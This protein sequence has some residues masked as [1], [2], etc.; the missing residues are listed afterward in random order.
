MV[1]FSYAQQELALSNLRVK[2]IRLSVSDTFITLDTFSIIPNSIEIFENGIR[3][4]PEFE[5][6]ESK[7]LLF[8]KNPQVRTLMITYRVLPFRTRYE[9]PMQAQLRESFKYTPRL[10]KAEAIKRFSY[11]KND[12]LDLDGISYNGS[13]YR[14][15]T[16]GN[17]QD[18]A[19]HSGFNMSLSG[20]LQ[21]G[22]EIN[23]S[24]TDA[25]IPLQPE[26]NSASLQEFDRI[27]IQLK[28]DNHQGIV[29]DFDVKNINE[30]YFLK[31]DRKLQG[32]T[33]HSKFDLDTSK[34]L[35]VGATAAITRGVFARNTFIAKEKNQGPY[36]LFGN[37]GESFLIIIAGTEKVFINGQLMKRGFDQDYVINYNIGEIV[38]TPKRLITQDLRIIV[39]F[40]YSDRNFFR[41][42]LEAHAVYRSTKSKLYAQIF[43]ESDNKNQPLNL[44]LN[45]S[46]ISR[47]KEIGNQIDSAYISSESLTTWDA[48]RITYQRKDTVVQNQNYSNIFKWAETPLDTVYTVI[49]TFVGAN[50]GHYNIKAS[51][52]NGTVF[53]WVA[54]Q[55]GIF[56]GSYEAIT[57]I[58]TPKSHLQAII[59]GDIKLNSWLQ[60]SAEVTYTQN[61]LNEFSEKDND[62]N[63]GTGA[64]L[65]LI[66]T[67]KIDSF[68]Q[69]S[70][71]IQNEYTSS[72]FSPVTRFRNLEFNRDWDLQIQSR[73]DVFQNMLTSNMA[74]QNKIIKLRTQWNAFFMDTMYQGLQNITDFEGEK[75]SIKWSLTSNVLKTK[76]LDSA[77]TFFRPKGTFN[78]SFLKKNPM[79]ASVGFAF[80]IKEKKAVNSENISTNS[81]DWKN[82]FFN[83]ASNPKASSRFNFG[84]IYRTER[85][86]DGITF[87]TPKI[88]SHTLNLNGVVEKNL[89]HLFKYNFSYRNFVNTDTG[90]KSKELIHNYLGRLDYNGQFLRGFMKINTLYELKAGQEQKTQITYVKAT[91]GY[92]NY[93]WKDLNN[94]G[95]FE[96]DEAYVSNFN[97]ENRYIRFYTLLPDFVPANEILFNHFLWLQPKAIWHSKKDWRK[98]ASKFSYQLRFDIQRKSTFS[99]SQTVSEFLSPFESVS[100]NN[101]IVS[102]FNLF[103][104]LAFQKNESNFGADLE[105]SYIDAKNLMSNGLESYATQLFNLKLRYNLS[106][107][108]TLLG[109]ISNGI[110]RNQSDFFADRNY[111]FILN[112][113]ENTLSILP[114]KN[115]KINL[116][117]N[118][119]FKSSNL[120]YLVQQQGDIELLLSRKN[121]GMVEAKFST[122][123]LNYGKIKDNP[124]V[125]LAML[126]GVQAGTNF[127]WSLNFGQK[128]TD[129]LQLNL[130]YNGR[131]NTQ[132]D[133]M[134]HSAN[135]EVR[136]IF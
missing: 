86:S 77:T 68:K 57:K 107:Y 21:N 129:L 103:N 54:P 7:A 135:M 78:Y 4:N 17:N 48:A 105:W 64:L 10:Y 15:V 24:I 136:A 63:S 13:L 56:Q 93:A 108:F 97:F 114:H 60:A 70:I 83:L 67:K 23:A 58:S 59:G 80:E 92:G 39:E 73:N 123:I 28:K 117:A 110:K 37:N 35:E 75:G 85:Y 124:Q 132:S 14:G 53:E 51:S 31:Y 90:I 5:Y 98:W 72:N 8:V 44:K 65:K 43:S 109:K 76:A 55:N 22:L 18:M 19:L 69:I 111:S 47:L 61:D 113:V 89:N 115:L 11:I 122:L 84:Y 36:R 49:F 131:K 12:K 33:Y 16:V 3:I 71:S 9:N 62:K 88:I 34:Q 104:Q 29:G 121:N 74:Y 120:Q 46:Q 126:N 99:Q 133:K 101:L 81:F 94:N 106:S 125:E 2:T 96:I 66:G 1:A 38:F 91:N 25:N 6:N 52:A 127:I 102:R 95:V 116:N 118:Y 41:S 100:S 79:T 32:L 119:A 30:S 128:L 27:F 20:R 42:T 82:Y 134:I 45:E 130:V 26:G 112:E 87:L 40:Q 50:K